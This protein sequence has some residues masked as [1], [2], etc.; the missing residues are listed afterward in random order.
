MQKDIVLV[1][2]AEWHHPFW[3]NKQHTAI[4]LARQGCRVLYIDS[5]GLRKPSVNS[6]DLSRIGR[7]LFRGL[8]LPE[9]VHDGIWVCSPLVI[10]AARWSFIQ[11]FNKL[12]MR[13]YLYFCQFYLK[14]NSPI[15]W[16]YNPLTLRLIDPSCY[17]KLIYHCVDD[18]SAQ[19]GMDSRQILVWER[20]LC[21]NADLVFVTSKNLL[22]T[23][24]EWNQSTHYLPNVVDLS[25]FKLSTDTDCDLTPPDLARIPGPRLLFV[26]AISGYKVDFALLRDLALLRP[27]WS[28]V[29]IGAVGEGDPDTDTDLLDDLPNVH[30]LGPKEYSDLP[31]YMSQCDVGL[32]PCLLNQYTINMFPMKFFEYLASG[33]PVVSTALPSLV[34]FKLFYDECKS[35]SEFE[36]KVENILS[37]K[38]ML[39]SLSVRSLLASNTYE[40]R[41]AKMLSIIDELSGGQEARVL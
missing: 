20:L 19:P 14:F 32:L 4:Q 8:R 12:I 23:R 26:G 6:R 41:T 30:F 11:R 35:V 9:K 34:D 1:S 3:T 27:E 39:D 33:L 31:R 29:L 22:K 40:A 17:E 38:T 10:P 28:I 5:L 15:M 21:E 36:C 24:A 18:I 7:R 16:T 2:T 37:G 13:F 25:Y